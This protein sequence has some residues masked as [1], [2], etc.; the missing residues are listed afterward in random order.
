[1]P[2]DV[3]RIAADWGEML[4]PDL[5]DSN[6]SFNPKNAKVN[7]LLAEALDASESDPQDLTPCNTEPPEDLL[8]EGSIQ[9]WMVNHRWKV[10]WFHISFFLVSLDGN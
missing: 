7:C 2:S 10:S 9:E 1:M 8:E 4:G 6:V 5:D 3:T